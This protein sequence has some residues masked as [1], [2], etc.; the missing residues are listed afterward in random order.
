MKIFYDIETSY[1]IGSFWSAGYGKDISPADILRERQIIC[2]SYK[3]EGADWTD[4]IY[5]DCLHKREGKNLKQSILMT[6][7][8]DKRLLEDW[9]EI[10]KDADELIAH[11]GDAFDDKWI[12]GRCIYHGLPYPKQLTID[13]YKESGKVGKFNSR[14]LDY[15]AQFF[16]VGMKIK[17]GGKSL[18]DRTMAGER[19]ALATMIEYCENDVLI[20]EKVYEKLKPYIK[21]KS[22]TGEGLCSACGSNNVG[23][24][25]KYTT[26]SRQNKVQTLCKDCGH[27]E[28]WPENRW[29]KWS[30]LLL[31]GA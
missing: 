24:H 30:S 13:T 26:E 11:N 23:V 29:I 2:I 17:T 15:L 3:I 22:L 18:W 20:L 21:M 9:L 28:A 16:D 31:H 12:R 5:W 19:D 25:K 10:T 14:K 7:H 8:C 4:T 27:F 1:N 6:E